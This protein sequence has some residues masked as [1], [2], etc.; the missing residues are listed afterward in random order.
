[1]TDEEINK[2]VAE[3]EGW[4][5][6][7]NPGTDR[8]LWFHPSDEDGTNV[9]ASLPPYATS[10]K[11]CGPLVEKHAIAIRPPE[12]ASW[13]AYALTGEKWNPENRHEAGWADTPQR[14]ICLVVI[15]AH[16]SEEN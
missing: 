8:L 10:W 5:S 16:N 3:I 11:W 15:A 14:A 2:Q 12:H 6:I 4:V 7:P 13:S 1:M 9:L